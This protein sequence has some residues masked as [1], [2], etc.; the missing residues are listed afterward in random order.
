MLHKHR[1]TTYKKSSTKDRR[2][3]VC[4]VVVYS[5]ECS[6]YK[7]TCNTLLHLKPAGGQETMEASSLAL[8]GVKG[9]NK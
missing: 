8:R 6:C 3:E 4:L 2:G 5:R 7:N 9:Q 1:N